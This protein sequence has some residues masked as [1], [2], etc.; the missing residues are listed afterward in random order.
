MTVKSK[1]MTWVL[2]KRYSEFLAF[3]QNLIQTADKVQL[4]PK[5]PPKMLFGNMKTHNIEKR[6]E[7][8][9]QYIQSLLAVQREIMV[10]KNCVQLFQLFFETKQMTEPIMDHGSRKKRVALRPSL[11]MVMWK[12]IV[13]H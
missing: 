1:T 6:K 5:F 12:S 10:S 2:K 8:L 4:L 13:I 11:R 3:S 7:K 9:N